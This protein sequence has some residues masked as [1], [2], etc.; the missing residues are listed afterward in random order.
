MLARARMQGS[1]CPLPDRGRG[2]L[3][4]TGKHIIFDIL[5]CQVMAGNVRPGGHDPP[6]SRLADGYSI[7]FE[8]RAQNEG[9]G[10]V[11]GITRLTSL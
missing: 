6:T 10:V 8:L 11:C 2:Y 9:Y 4:L 7:Q 3:T 1:A 5:T